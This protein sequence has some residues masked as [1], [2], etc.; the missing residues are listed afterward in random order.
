VL[1]L[2]QMMF[3]CRLLNK[4]RATINHLIIFHWI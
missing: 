3:W 2:L 1:V 4:T